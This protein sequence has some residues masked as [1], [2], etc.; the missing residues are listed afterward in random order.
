MYMR[1]LEGRQ[2]QA[3]RRRQEM[4]AQTHR[5]RLHS[6]KHWAGL[7]AQRG[8]RGRISHLRRGVCR[9]AHSHTASL[10]QAW[11]QGKLAGAGSSVQP[12]QTKAAALLIAAQGA[13]AAPQQHA[14]RAKRAKPQILLT[15]KHMAT[16]VHRRFHPAV[17][18]APAARAPCN[19]QWNALSV[20][21]SCRSVRPPASCGKQDR[22]RQIH[23]RRNKGGAPRNAL[24][25]AKAQ[26]AL[27][28]R[29]GK[30]TA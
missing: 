8:R 3:V 5:S 13:C 9:H 30:P 15:T 2:A 12:L 14:Q 20:S 17:S 26:Q 23:A 18:L 25:P 22:A 6:R 19:P 4:A 16:I 11:R 10:A 28:T 24:D 1:R 21:R 27:L 7:K 29:A